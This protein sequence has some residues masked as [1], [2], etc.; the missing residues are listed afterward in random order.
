MKHDLTF[1]LRLLRRNPAYAAI[2][3]LTIALGV[4]AN[5]A[6]FS[7]VDSVLFRRLPFRNAGRLFALRA[8]DP[9]LGKYS[10]TLPVGVIDA[11]TATG[12][13]DGIAPASSR[14]WRAYIRTDSGLDA[15]SLAPVSSRYLELLGVEPLLGRTLSGAA[16]GTRP[17]LLTYRAWMQ[18]Y[19]GDPSVIGR[20]V[21]VILRP[22][23]K[24]PLVQPPLQIVGVL[25]PHVRL[26]LVAPAD[27]LIVDDVETS[28]FAPM[29]RL[30]PDVGLAAAQSRLETIRTAELR[31]SHSELR[32]VSVRE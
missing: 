2:A 17:I 1:A 8:F 3:V 19:G 4:G 21:A 32:L 9:A 30:R 13:F 20:L 27:G 29:V 18:R 10:G 25:A 6:I 5:T 16:P 26:P 23:E 11:A 14:A 12:L 31:T 28:G 22:T 7:I 15:L 24:Y